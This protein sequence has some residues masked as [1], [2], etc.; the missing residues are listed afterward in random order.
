MV[1]VENIGLGWVSILDEEEV[2]IIFNVFWENELIVYLC[3]GYVIEFI[4][5][6]LLEIFNWEKCK[7]KEMVIYC[8]NYDY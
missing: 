6:F 7:L 8:D 4:E 5:C 1:R 3:I 2:K